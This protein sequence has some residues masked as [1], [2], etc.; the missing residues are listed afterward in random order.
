ML[1]W[2][3]FWFGPACCGVSFP[4]SVSQEEVEISLSVELAYETGWE[5]G[6]ELRVQ[7]LRSRRRCISVRSPCINTQHS[8][9]P[10]LP[11]GAHLHVLH[12]QNPPAGVLNHAALLRRLPQPWQGP[13]VPLSSGSFK[14]IPLREGCRAHG[15]VGV[16]VMADDVSLGGDKE[17]A[18][19]CPVL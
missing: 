8:D 6:G 11:R 7:S 1:S 17:E 12:T 18:P 3:K 16:G 4:G 5:W 13:R 9:G 10:L 19:T 14:R 15:K 2:A